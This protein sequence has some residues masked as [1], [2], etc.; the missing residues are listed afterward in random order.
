MLVQEKAKIIKIRGSITFYKSGIIENHPKNRSSGQKVGYTAKTNIP[1]II[2]N[3]F[4]A[5]ELKRIYS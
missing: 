4:K 2:P 1:F 5:T 3:F